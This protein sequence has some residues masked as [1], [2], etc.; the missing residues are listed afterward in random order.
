[1]SLLN[2]S[3]WFA[4]SETSGGGFY[5]YLIDT[6]LRFLDDLG[7][8]LNRTPS[9][10]SNSKTWT[11]SGWLKRGNIASN[12]GFFSAYSS[13]LSLDSFSFNSEDRL[14]FR[15]Y[16]GTSYNI[17]TDSIFSDPSSWYHI[18][19]FVDTTQATASDRVKIFVN[20]EQEG[21]STATYPSQNYDF[22]VNT[23][24][25]HLIGY[26]SN[27][28][29]DGY[30]SEVNFID[31][32]AL[33]PTYFGE[34]KDNVW[35]PKEYS[36]TYG[37]NGF[38][39][40]FSDNTT[41]TSLAL[42]Y[43][44][45]GN[46]WSVN[47]TATTDKIPDSPTNNFCTLNP[48]VYRRG[49]TTLPSYS[50]GNLS[51][52]T[53]DAG[54]NDLM[55]AGTFSLTSGKWYFETYITS[56]ATAYPATGITIGIADRQYDEVTDSLIGYLAN[57]GSL[58]RYG[59]P[60]A[61]GATFTTGDIIG[62]AFDLDTSSMTCYK[63]GVSQGTIGGTWSST[64][65]PTVF[66]QSNTSDNYYMNF[67][68]DGSF[69]GVTSSGNYSDDNLVGNFKY[70]PPSGYLAICS[71]NL[72]E[73]V[74]ID[75]VENFNSVGYAGS[76][77]TNSINGVGFQPDFVWVKS[78]Y[79]VQD[80]ALFNSVTGVTK[81]LSSNLA[82][83][84]TT[85]SSTLTSFD[86]DGYTMGTGFTNQSGYSY[87]SWNWKAGGTATSNTDGS[88]TSNVSSN[89]NAGFSIVS[90]TASSSASTIGHGLTKAP[91][92]IIQ[93]NRDV[94]GDWGIYQKD[95][96]A[97]KYFSLNSAA[98]PITSSVPWDNT[99]P[100]TSVFSIGNGYTNGNEYVAYCFN[101]VEG[102]SKTGSYVGNG[103]ANGSFIYTGFKPAFI[104]I[105]G[106][107]DAYNWTIYDSARDPT[108]FLDSILYPNLDV[109]ENTGLPR[110]NFLSNG[111]KNL[112]PDNDNVNNQTYVYLAFAENPFKYANAR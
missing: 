69:A 99:A 11:W 17:L 53:P 93:K 20:G 13:S 62:I 5:P 33:D 58:Y 63:N 92:M 110:F 86:T 54:G 83:A 12:Y 102:F 45:N 8:Y 68:Q 112:D 72:L 1:M 50:H 27:S 14:L 28:F 38:Y 78:R 36:G 106:I 97:T 48:L 101:N 64:N 61:T 40:K 44:G 4:A 15:N 70:Q 55:A 6:S 19:L 109:V 76:G 31:G 43:S 74:I 3:M 10:S 25:S 57:S 75:G 51:V 71:K 108:N 90:Y 59:T 49:V 2:N 88:I 104:M 79:N 46:N 100:T 82:S 103:N 95:V 96:G 56:F 32:Q 81:Y 34:F 35:I 98:V 47:N 22:L 111:F 80:H 94:S 89:I 7:Q 91:D 73:P 66:I 84:E 24:I 9:S 67:G 65:S 85:N 107:T 60:V 29:F 30:L 42:D 39:L 105:K 52:V 18:I 21:T 41:A 87:I 26:D 16:N 23:S 37:T 77:A